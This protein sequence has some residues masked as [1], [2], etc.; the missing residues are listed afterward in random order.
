MNTDTAVELVRQ[1][2]YLGLLLAAPVLAVSV[3]AGLVMGILQAVT[4]IQEQTLSFVPRLIVAVLTIVAV[5]PW[6]IGRLVE[7]A[8]TLYQE[9]PSTF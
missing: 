8:Q 1:A 6:T 9:M 3:A 2:V 4:Q 5:L 7:Y